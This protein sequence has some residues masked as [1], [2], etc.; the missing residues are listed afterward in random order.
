MS[1]N[2]RVVVTQQNNYQFL[3]DFG[4]AFP[5]VMADEPPPLGE[6]TGPS[7]SDLLLAGVANCLT[8]SLLFALRKFKQ[9]AGGLT[10]TATAT[11]DRNEE[12]RLR[13]QEIA[14]AITLGK[15]GREIEQLDKILGQFEAFCTV[16]MSVRQGIPIVVTVDDAE[17]TRVK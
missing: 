8:A 9:D 13:V 12:K 4:G 16:S 2:A 5:A 3:V 7:P 14:V 11:I 1:S 15:A 10:A 17:G 6:G